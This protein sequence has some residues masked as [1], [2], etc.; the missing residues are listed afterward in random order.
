MQEREE[1]VK[2]RP[3]ILSTLYFLTPVILLALGAYLV[4]YLQK[5]RLNRNEWDCQ[6]KGQEHYQERKKEFEEEEKKNLGLTINM[7]MDGPRYKYNKELETCLYFEDVMKMGIEK[8]VNLETKCIKDL[9]TGQCIV[10]F[11]GGNV[12]NTDWK[13]EDE[14]FIKRANEL[15]G[16]F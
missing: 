1:E 8:D 2:K 5:E 13:K 16:K 3:P 4:F 14:E 10:S 9:K 15:M 6:K 11:I 12:T 7:F